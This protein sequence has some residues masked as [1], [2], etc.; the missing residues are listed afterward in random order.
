MVKAF[1]DAEEA[2][3]VKIGEFIFLLKPL[4]GGESSSLT[5]KA[6]K[7]TDARRGQVDLDSKIAAEERLKAVIVDWNIGKDG[8]VVDMDDDENKAE[9]TVENIS[10]L[11]DSIHGRILDESRKLDEIPE[12]V[13]KD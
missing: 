13:K 8:S 5:D 12:E 1:A 2:K 6:I 4:S 9:I 10:R 7:V 11:K 3:E